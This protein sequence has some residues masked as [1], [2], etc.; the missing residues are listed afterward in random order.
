MGNERGQKYEKPSDIPINGENNM[1]KGFVINEAG[2]KLV[3]YYEGCFLKSY[4]DSVGVWTIGLGRI[5]YSNGTFVGANET[6]TQEQAD[7]W[8]REDLE[9]EGAHYVRAWTNGLNEN[10][11]S[12][13]VS[14]CFNRGAGRLRELLAMPGS[15]ETNII[16]F[17]YAGSFTNHLLGLQRRRRSERSLYI[18]NNWEEFKNWK[19]N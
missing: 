13:L 4:Q 5:R 10:Q 18:G 17:D 6:C 12:A 3:E 8:L 14:F 16:H 7:A 19:P 9:K 1:D 2:L 11:F 15:I